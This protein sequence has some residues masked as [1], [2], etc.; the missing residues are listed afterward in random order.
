M[1][2]SEK[3]FDV[4]ITKNLN[5]KQNNFCKISNNFHDWVSKMNIIAFKYLKRKFNM[6]DWYNHNGTVLLLI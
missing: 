2:S 6:W 4:G 1:Y 3:I 5:E